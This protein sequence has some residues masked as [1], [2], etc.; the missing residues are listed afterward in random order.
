VGRDEAVE[1]DVAWTGRSSTSEFK[2]FENIVGLGGGLND[3]VEASTCV[4]LSPVSH[5]LVVVAKIAPEGH[6]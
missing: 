5:H 3:V 6:G 4:C 2:D 1:V